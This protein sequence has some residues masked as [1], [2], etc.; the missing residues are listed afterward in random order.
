MQTSFPIHEIFTSIQGESTFAGLPCT[1]VRFAA[2]NLRCS[3]CDTRKAWTDEHARRCTA[4]EILDAVESA[5][6]PLVELTGGEPLLQPG[7]PSLADAILARGFH[8]LLE[9]NGSL[10]AA[11]VPFD[12]I[13]IFDYKL[14]SSGEESRMLD[15]NFRTLRPSDQVKFVVGT[16]DDFFAACA[17]VDH[18]RMADQ[19][20]NLLFS[21]VFGQMEFP[22]LAALIVQSKRPFRLNLQLHKIIWG[23]DAEGV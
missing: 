12:V 19:T 14:P 17:A 7:L 22:R 3:Y 4:G 5:A 13:R 9:T 2:C 23:P 10:D 8:V 15:T 16:P 18:F 21:P 1:F 11:H 6:L 20:P